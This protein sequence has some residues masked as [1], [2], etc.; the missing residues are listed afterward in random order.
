MKQRKTG[1]L[2]DNKKR[3][4]LIQELTQLYKA[5]G[6]VQISIPIYEPESDV[7]NGNSKKSVRFVDPTKGILTLQNDPT[8][9]MMKMLQQEKLNDVNKFCYY[10]NTFGYQ[11]N[12]LQEMTQIGL[13]YYGISEAASDAEIVVLAI[14]S[15]LRINKE[16][17]VEVSELRLY[18]A[19]EAIINQMAPD[20]E[21][22][23]FLLSTKNIPGIRR[24][25]LP[26]ALE[27]LLIEY[28]GCTGSPKEVIERAKR[29]IE[30][31]LF[32]KKN[33][34]TQAI[35]YLEEI[36]EIVEAYELSS[37]FSL[38]LTIF[39]EY[40][41]YNGIFFK[42]Y[43]KNCPTEI[44]SGGRYDLLSAEYGK[45]IPA[46][47]FAIKIDKILSTMA[48]KPIYRPN[49]IMICEHKI[50]ESGIQIA[51]LYR[52]KGFIVDIRSYQ[53]EKAAIDLALA[54]SVENI[55][56]LSDKTAK[57]INLRKDEIVK[58][59]IGEF[60]GKVSVTFKNESIH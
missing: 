57:V 45:P 8:T 20:P 46:C 14:K 44:C 56:L 55:V 22:V 36:V 28:L 58:Y 7:K 6:Y 24:E 12:T 42:G 59:P 1:S 38:D 53:S 29:F 52:S 17:L 21:R 43:L 34:L 47:G 30:N 40:K 19:V 15:L 13:E 41:Y 37:Y 23:R 25:M 9:A 16:A 33:A 49:A 2:V 4:A 54:Q 26:E 5:H 32:K 31:P 35:H 18:K 3:Y 50:S 10:A 11:A 48:V 60:K 27:A 39:G 51:E